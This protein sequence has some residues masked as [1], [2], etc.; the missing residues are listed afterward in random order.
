M[1]EDSA[2]DMF[3]FIS[4]CDVCVTAAREAGILDG[5]DTLQEAVLADYVIQMRKQDTWGTNIE[6][7]MLSRLREVNVMVTMRTSRGLNRY[8]VEDE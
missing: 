4:Q 8:H 1:I 5:Q 7:L 2:D 6:L 3:P